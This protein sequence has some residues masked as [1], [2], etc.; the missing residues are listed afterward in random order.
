MSTGLPAVCRAA[1]RFGWVTM[2]YLPYVVQV[3]PAVDRSLCF[4]HCH[5]HTADLADRSLNRVAG[6]D[7]GDAL[8]GPGHQNVAGKQRI[9]RRGVF[10]Q[11]GD[12]LDQ[13]SG[14]GLLPDFAADR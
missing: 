4:S 11:L 2:R 1:S 13:V 14:I 10:N 6:I 12:F 3:R 9:E 7:G 5:T 8:R